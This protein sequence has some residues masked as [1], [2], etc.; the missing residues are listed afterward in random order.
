[1]F[2]VE[3]KVRSSLPSDLCIAVKKDIGKGVIWYSLLCAEIVEFLQLAK[4]KSV[5]A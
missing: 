2:G 5:K 1:M 4:P 3:D